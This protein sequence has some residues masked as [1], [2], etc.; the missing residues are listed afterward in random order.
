MDNYEDLGMDIFAEQLKSLYFSGI[1]C[2]YLLANL[3]S[4]HNPG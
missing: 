4:G 3:I 2:S 1:Y